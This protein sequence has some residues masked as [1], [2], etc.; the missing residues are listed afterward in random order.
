MKNIYL[1]IYYIAG[2][3]LGLQFSKISL[4]LKNFTLEIFVNWD[5][6]YIYVAN[7][8]SQFS[9]HLVKYCIFMHIYMITSVKL[10]YSQ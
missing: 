3:L 9:S 6:V 4:N 10:L 2:K 1:Y 8:Q 7:L 5:T